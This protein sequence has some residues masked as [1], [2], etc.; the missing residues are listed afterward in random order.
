MEW[1]PVQPGT[2]DVNALFAALLY[3]AVQSPLP[4]A[5]IIAYGIWS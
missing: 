4:D 3:A 2:K 1:C 5:S